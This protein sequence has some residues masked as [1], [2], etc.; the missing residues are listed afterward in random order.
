MGFEPAELTEH[1]DALYRYA[2][3]VTR[4]PDLAADTVQDTLVR[5]IDRH[6]QYRQTARLD[7]I[8]HQR[9][10]TD[11]FIR[12]DPQNLRFQGCQYAVA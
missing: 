11:E 3:G 2:L 8:A 12:A 9:R 4:D 6:D 7:Q 10:W 1:L 5:A